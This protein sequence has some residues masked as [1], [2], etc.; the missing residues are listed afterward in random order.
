MYVN[1]GNS[2]DNCSCDSYEKS[3]Q[4]IDKIISELDIILENKDKKELD[5]VKKTRNIKA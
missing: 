1:N 3:P 2:I 4:K 5:K